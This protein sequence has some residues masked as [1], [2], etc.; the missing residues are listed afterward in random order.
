MNKA[1]HAGQTPLSLAAS[2]GAA[3]LVEFL[4]TL[5]A[6]ADARVGV[7]LNVGPRK[8]ET[9]PTSKRLTGRGTPA[10]GSRESEGRPSSARALRATY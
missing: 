6:K 10:R 1:N 8:E 5:G 4:L 3:S 9:P 7:L 2:D